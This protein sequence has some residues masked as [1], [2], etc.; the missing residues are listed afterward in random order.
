MPQVLLS[1]VLTSTITFIAIVLGYLTYSIDVELTNVVD[2]LAIRNIRRLLRMG[3]GT[4][5]PIKT[6][7]T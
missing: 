7:Q 2:R 3:D 1:F 6:K 4:D 5:I